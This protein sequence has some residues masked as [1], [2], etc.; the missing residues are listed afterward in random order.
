MLTVVWVDAALEMHILQN[1]PI[2]RFTCSCRA[3][4]DP[5]SPHPRIHQEHTPKTP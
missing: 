4:P 3:Q 2:I 5:I 1:I